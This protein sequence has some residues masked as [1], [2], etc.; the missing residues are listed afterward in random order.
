[1][2]RIATRMTHTDPLAEQGALAI[3][4][5][6]W[7]ICH[8]EVTTMEDYVKLLRVRLSS[9]KDD[10]L[11]V[12]L[13]QV[14]ESIRTGESTTDFAGR[15]CRRGAWGVSG[16]VLETVPVCL[17]A[18]LSCRRDY[19][20]AV[21]SVIS[22]G[23]DADTTAAIADAIAGS[24]CGASGRQYTSRIAEWPAGVAWQMDLSKQ[25]TEGMETVIP[26]QSHS[27]FWVSRLLRNLGFVVPVLFH[28]F[29]LLLPPW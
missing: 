15:F 27:I 26:D 28:G 22:F 1:M 29:R 9:R 8:T 25:F 10:R 18:W 16:F 19:G 24:E 23:G 3:A 2:T 5:G 13:E 21:R 17:H 20:A 12:S 11:L 14:N 4:M 6:A 7:F